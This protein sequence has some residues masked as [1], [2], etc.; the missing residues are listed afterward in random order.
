MTAFAQI[1][2]PFIASEAAGFLAVFKPAGMHSVPDFALWLAAARPQLAERFAALDDALIHP[3]IKA[4][5][6]MLSRLDRATSGLVIF[7]S[8]PEAFLAALE[9]RQQGRM[10]KQ[11]RLIVARAEGSGELPGSRPL[12]CP[13]P[14]IGPLFDRAGEAK[15]GALTIASYFRSY[16]EKGAR[17]ACVAADS[18]NETKKPLSPNLHT[19]T[20]LRVRGTSIGDIADSGHVVEVEA[21]IASGFRHQIRAHLAWAGYPIVGDSLYGG[22]AASRL[23]LECHRVEL[24]LQGSPPLVFESYDPS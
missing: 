19:T 12:R 4:E 14:G 18:R 22:R 7:A 6:G 20:I 1:A 16:G 13:V 8:S 2:E 23:W 9:A 11:Y 24:A 15:E 10:L 5:L 21:A 17:V 3:R